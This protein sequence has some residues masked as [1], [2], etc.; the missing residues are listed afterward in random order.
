MFYNYKLLGFLRKLPSADESKSTIGFALVVLMTLF[1]FSEMQAQTTLINPA[2]DGGFNSGTTFSAN[3]WT[4][5]NQGN[6]AVKWVVG[7]AVS[8][9]AI[10]GNSAYV[11]LD[12]GETNSSAGI[13]G[14]RTVYFYKDI[15]IPA[16]QTNIALTFNWKAVGTSW[17]VFV[18]PTSVTPTGTDLQ[19][20]VPATV[21]GATSV[22]YNS[23]TGTGVTQNAFGFI[24]PSFAGTTA[25][26]IFMWSNGSGGGS[27][28]PAA[29]DNI[30]V[31]SRAGGNEIA[32]VASGN[33]TNP[34]TWDVGYVPSPADDIVINVDNT[35]TI[36][37]RNLGANNMYVAGANAVVQFG[38]VSDEFTI[39]NDLLI[40]GSGARFNVYEGGNGKSLKVGHDITL[41]SGGRL[42]VSVGSTTANAGALNLFGSTLQTISS[43]GT[44]IIGGTVS[45][46]GTTNTAGIIN[47]LVV[48]NTSTAIPNIDWQLN[49]IRIK[50]ILRLNSGRVKLGGNKIILGN[51]AA[52]SATNFTCNL[53]SGFIGGT[54]SRWY[55]TSAT[56][57]TIDPGIDYNP[58]TAALFP[59][60]SLTGK[61]RWAF[62]I[63]SAAT[64]AGELSLTYNDANTV[65][66]GL[67]ISDGSYTVTNRYDGNWL[68]ST[69]GSTY[70]NASGTF[71][72][73]LYAT[74][75]YN[76]NDGN[77]RIVN[78]AS[79]GLGTHINGTTNPFAARSGFTLANLTAA[80]FYVGSGASSIQSSTTKTSVASGDWND[81]ATWS[82]NGVPTCSD[83][84]TIASGHVV[85]VNAS[86][87]AAGV[88]NNGSLINSAGT[89]T[90]GCT[91]NNSIFTN[92]GIHTVSGGTLTVNGSVYHRF[93]STF[94]HTGG[95]IIVDSNAAGDP[96]NSVGQGGSSFKIETSNL[97]LTG[98]KIT[99]VDPLVN[100]TV[101]TSATSAINYTMPTLGAAGTFNA[102]AGAAIAGATTVSIST[103]SGGP[104]YGAGQTVTGAGIAPGTTVVSMTVPLVGFSL[105][106]ELSQPLTAAI[107]ASTPLTFSSMA[108][109]CSVVNFSNNSATNANWAN[110]A[111]GQEVSGN[112]IQP[113]TKIVSIAGGIDGNAAIFLSQPVSGLTASPITAPE[114]LT[115]SAASTGSSVIVLSAAN[116]A[117]LVGQ[118]VAGTGV[119]PATTVTAIN[120]NRIDL[121]Q[122]LVGTVVT[123]LA[124]SFYDGN[125]NS[126]AFAYNSS[127]NYAAGL[128][129]TLQ[130]GD[131]VSTEKAA[132]TTNGY[133][134]NLVQGGGIL[135]LGNLIV[136]APDGANRFFNAV[137]ALFIQNNTTVTTGS[138]FKKTNTTTGIAFGGNVVNNGSMFVGTNSIYLA[139]AYNTTS[140]SA[141]ATTLPQMISGSGIFYNNLNSAL[142]TGSF[143]SLTI[144]NTSPQGVT[145]SAPNFRVTSNITMTA[146]I[147]HTSAATPL[148]NGL[149]DLSN[150]G[151][152]S[153]NFSDTCFIDGPFSRSIGTNQTTLLFLYPVGKTGYTPI[154]ISASGGAN[155][156]AEAFTSNAGTTSTDIA[157]LSATRWKVTRNGSAGAFANFNVMVGDDTITANNIVVQAPTDEGVYDNVLGTTATFAA[158]TP[159]TLSTITAIPGTDF[160]G[161]FAY[162]TAPNCSTVIPGN[163]IA[164]LSVSRI[165]TLQTSTA[166][167]VTTGSAT[168]TLSAANALITAGLY[169]TGTGIPAGTTV[170]AISGTT[171]TLSQPATLTSTSTVS[172][173]FTAI[174]IPTTLC[175]TQPVRLSLQNPVAGYGV[176]YQWQSSANGTTFTDISDATSATYTA[177]P[178]GSAYYQCV[179]TCPYGPATATSTPVEVT[180]ANDAPTVT[181]DTICAP[182]V[183]SLEAAAASGTINWYA[184]ATSGTVLATGTTYAPTV[185]ATTTYYVSAE[186]T[187]TYT[188]GKSLTGTLTQTTPFSGIVFNTSTNV[189]LNS[190]K[191]YPKQTAGAIDAGAP[192]T[193]KLFKD[194]VQVPGTSAVTFTPAT[195]TGAVTATVSNVVTLDYNIP[196]GTGYKLLITNGLSSSNTVARITSF[197][198]A[199]P[200]GVGA[201]SVTGGAASFDGTPDAG[202][203]NFFD[204][205]VTEVCS[206]ERV[207]VVATVGCAPVQD[208]ATIGT[209]VTTAVTCFGGTDGSATITMSAL[210]PSVA[211]ISYTVDGGSSQNATLVSGAFTINGLSVGTHSVVVSNAG[212]PD[213]TVSVTIAGPT[214]QLTNTT[215]QA[216]CGSYTWTVTGLTYTTG[217]TY[218]GT[219]TNGDGCTVNETL[220]LTVTPNTTNST[221]VSAC[222]TYT[223]SVNGTT[224]TVG[225][226]YTS[227]IGCHTETLVL[228]INTSATI[229]G[230]STQIIP[231][232]NLNDATLEDLVVSP[233][234]VIW[235]ASLAE[236]L[237]PT[238]PLAVTTVLTSGA[239]YYAVNITS[240]CPSTP[241]AVTATVTLATAGFDNANF[242]FY[243]NPTSGILTLAYSTNITQVS[244]YNLIGQLV[245]D[246]KT[247]LNEVQLDLSSLTSA[248]YFVKVITEEGDSKVVK[249]IKQN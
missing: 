94:N 230:A 144:N 152:I 120:G 198:A 213:V 178:S 221:T 132:V 5:A 136:D 107:P 154:S 20:T 186:N 224:Y 70:A 100:N 165:I 40:S 167:G 58:S 111:A 62:I 124:L 169:V 141:V 27:N 159:N 105:T 45:A 189:R 211:A 38:A 14:A 66:T 242:R 80:P 10:T 50:S 112:G 53:G 108:N 97:N 37:A 218:T 60:L 229:T 21:A 133:L 42:D 171:L 180:F 4:V 137:N 223:W 24:P 61:N 93:G 77:S 115:F 161:N 7:T 106:L 16:G 243:P 174:E 17:Q 81:S 11:S 249:V 47:Q 183:A 147:V 248:T 130:I 118:T 246:R 156:T 13:S 123:P 9:G 12:N 188:A 239:T 150:S 226:T 204:L 90:V 95:D 23:T 28:P 31:V 119:Q 29:I 69:S 212:C 72:L 193:I 113:G 216:V 127:A 44:G 227:T 149:A 195:N 241:F 110:V 175:G 162:A 182:G 197:P 170:A 160:T 68:V 51:Y 125:L 73:G 103:L 55:A 163:T 1:S 173:T 128:N 219:T 96:A 217:G 181:P 215:T 232:T 236:A 3:G 172:L 177:T 104:I 59:A 139:S 86:A 233:S 33:F 85:T 22:L 15:T 43:D 205:N 116:P 201:V 63:S 196:A 19:L 164:D 121:S 64:T 67:S 126:Y 74:G 203:Y 231:V 122:P 247:N 8:S 78:I 220:N 155:F 76:S 146:G 237:V 157:N 153:G 46:T 199:T 194:G 134:C 84:V 148:H 34:A 2:T 48:S 184:S 99:I 238:N 52:I 228:T 209:A 244:V 89:M 235:Y 185:A 41:A 143:T 26:L 214:A 54:I 245:L 208:C 192:L 102:N 222:N 35:V 158:G 145:I 168:V 65:A 140:F 166:T 36:D 6:G 91:N 92:Y 206:S 101:A 142:A 49:N 187:S 176:L 234:N 240:G 151:I 82:P 87:N 56:G 210:T 138:V 30:S 39:S 18:A 109:G 83:V 131:A 191:I 25:R 190:V 135:S 117:I 88:I 57:V 129:H 75:A 98:G 202:Y 207:P 32:S 114:T 179:V 71:S 225:G 200:H 79:G